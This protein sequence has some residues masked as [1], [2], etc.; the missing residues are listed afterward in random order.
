MPLFFTKTMA[1]MNKLFI[2]FSG[3]NREMWT[4]WED[5]IKSYHLSSNFWCTTL[6]RGCESDGTIYEMGTIGV[7]LLT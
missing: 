3:V 5:G 2:V 4:A 1:N 7:K 6:Q